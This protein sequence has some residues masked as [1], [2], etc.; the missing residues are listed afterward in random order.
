MIFTAHLATTCAGVLGGDGEVGRLSG[1]AVHET[2]TVRGHVAARDR[3]HVELERGTC[4]QEG[5]GGQRLVGVARGETDNGLS[6]TVIVS[7]D[8]VT[9][10][11]EMVGGS[12][13]ELWFSIQD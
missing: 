3:V 5:G 4:R 7:H 13:T 8:T 11:V 2:G 10:T 12:I 6:S 1:D 9:Y